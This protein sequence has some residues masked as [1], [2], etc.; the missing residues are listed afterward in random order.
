MLNASP[1]RDI[2]RTDLG[3]DIFYLVIG[4]LS[5]EGF[6]S[7]V[8]RMALVARRFMF[9]A[10]RKTFRRVVIGSGVR[11]RRTAAEMEEWIRLLKELFEA[12]NR[13][14]LRSC[15]EE[16]VLFAGRPDQSWVT[17]GDLRWFMDSVSR[18]GAFKRFSLISGCLSPWNMRLFRPEFWRACGECVVELALVNV[19]QIDLAEIL[20]RLPNVESVT[21]SA[22]DSSST[23]AV[24]EGDKTTR[25]KKLV[26]MSRSA[27]LP[28]F[29]RVDEILNRDLDAHLDIS[30]FSEVVLRTDRGADAQFAVTVLKGSG[31]ALRKVTMNV[32]GALANRHFFED[33]SGP[34]NGLEHLYLWSE[35]GNWWCQVQQA[36]RIQA[37]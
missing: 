35:F 25:I 2:A 12:S 5:D 10:H 15:V 11:K 13:D 9:M 3:D 16:V 19:S 33:F 18:G 29:G 1:I 28:H 17:C 34:K 22:V 37:R 30:S 8:R 31:T 36:V 14:W 4:I 21:V 32:R 26:H 23:L 7:A 24:N 6:T 27:V 20:A